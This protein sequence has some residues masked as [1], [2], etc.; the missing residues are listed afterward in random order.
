MN[1]KRIIAML[2][3]AIM[4]LSLIP[5]VAISTAAAE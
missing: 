5:V 2:I 1:T 3:A 4:V